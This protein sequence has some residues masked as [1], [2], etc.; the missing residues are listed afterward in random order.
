MLTDNMN[1]KIQLATCVFAGDVD[2]SPILG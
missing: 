1:D 2:K